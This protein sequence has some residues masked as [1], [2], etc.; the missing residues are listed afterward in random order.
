MTDYFALEDYPWFY[1]CPHCR[2][3]AFYLKEEPRLGDYADAA[4]AIGIHG[5]VIQE[6]DLVRCFACGE[7]IHKA[8]RIGKVLKR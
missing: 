3:P 5:E 1:P 6:G 4:K 2:Q 7:E 8:F